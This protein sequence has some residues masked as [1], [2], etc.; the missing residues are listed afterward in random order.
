MGQLKLPRA[1]AIFCRAAGVFDV[2]QDNCSLV[3]DGWDFAAYCNSGAAYN[4]KVVICQ[5]A[6]ELQQPQSHLGLW[7]LAILQGK[8]RDNKK[9]RDER[10]YSQLEGVEREV[11]WKNQSS[12]LGRTKP[13]WLRLVY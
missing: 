3:L 6:L 5:E 7:L 13:E 4:P 12:G 9:G 1:A 10:E 11:P 2:S 8:V